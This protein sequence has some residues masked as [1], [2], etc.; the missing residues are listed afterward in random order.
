MNRHYYILAIAIVYI[1]TA[2]FSVGYMHPDEHY[3]ILEFAGYK[4][5]LS[6][7]ADLPWEFYAQIRQ[8]IQVFPVVYLYRFFQLFTAP[9]QLVNPFVIA[10]ITRLFSAA[11]SI[12]A[13]YLFFVRFQAELKSDALKKWMLLL[14]FF[15]YLVV[16]NSVRYSGENISSK[17]FI[18]GLCFLFSPTVRKNMALYWHYLLC[19]ILLGLG[20]YVRYEIGFMIFGL[21]MWLLCI[22]RLQI[23]LWMMIAAGILIAMGVGVAIDCWFYGHWVISAWR[24]FESNV[25]KNG[26][27][28]FGTHQWFYYL[29]IARYWPY[30]IVYI[31]STLYFIDRFRKHVLTWIMVPFLLVHLSVAHKELR[32]LI[33]LLPLMPL[34]VMLSVQSSKNALYRIIKPIYCSI[35]VRFAWYLN[36]AVLLI[37]VMFIPAADEVPLLNTVFTHYQKPVM[38]YKMCNEFLGSKQCEQHYVSSLPFTKHPEAYYLTHTPLTPFTSNLEPN[39]YKRPHTIIIHYFNR[40]QCKKGFTCL[41]AMNCYQAKLF[42][43]LFD[44]TLI[45]SECPAWIY[46]INITNWLSRS[47]GLENVYEVQSEPRPEKAGVRVR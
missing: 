2:F 37:G 36:C 40:V 6:H 10:F 23:K 8:T 15:S 5:G 46:K 28:A 9:G 30:G 32:F 12:Y 11:L 4:L 34:V 22:Q 35:I 1:C 13:A 41:L 18:I 25:V 21:M 7:P 27:S 19:G 3:Q 31:F 24:Y 42:A 29:A 16:F 33:P 44:A 45:S 26:A 17:L 38:V 43:H 47:N 20:F 14:S 39:F